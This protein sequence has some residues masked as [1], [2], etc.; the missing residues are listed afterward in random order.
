[1]SSGHTA[2]LSWRARGSHGPNYQ[3]RSLSG[4]NA[5]YFGEILKFWL[6][7]SPPSTGSKSKVSKK[8]AE[9]D[10]KP[11]P[12]DDSSLVSCFTYSSPLKKEMA[13]ASWNIGL[14][15]NYMALQRTWP[16]INEIFGH[17]K[18]LMSNHWTRH[19]KPTDCMWSEILTAM[20][21]NI[22]KVPTVQ[23]KLWPPS[24]E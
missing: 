15:P 13:C 7:T 21:T 2:S 23:R 20:N 10:G 14:S 6:N 17:V 9:A 24:S 18:S 4:W 12:A 19:L 1:M 16:E 3:M 11:R 5:L 8:L 22:R